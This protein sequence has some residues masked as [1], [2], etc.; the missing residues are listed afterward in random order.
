MKALLGVVVGAFVLASL[1]AGGVGS[2]K[3]SLAFTSLQPLSVHGRHFAAHERV[4]VT[5][6]VGKAPGHV[7]VVRTSATGAFTTSPPAGIGYDRC[8]TTLVVSAV[9]A[10]G[11][12]ALLNRPPRGCAPAGT[13]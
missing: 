2:S 12:K 6:V 13:A 3:P 7:R 11:D 1:A 8:T 4:R 10:R 5:F 9:G